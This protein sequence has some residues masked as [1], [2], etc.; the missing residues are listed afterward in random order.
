M[1]GQFADAANIGVLVLN[2]HSNTRTIPETQ[3][4]ARDAENAI[5]GGTRVVGAYDF[6]EVAVP[7]E[8]FQANRNYEFA[9]EDLAEKDMLSE[10]PMGLL[11]KEDLSPKDDNQ[12][13]KL[14]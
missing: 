4:T 7:R 10:P 8:G 14:I 6:M 3:Q 1:A 2:H 13:K 11:P 9:P 5:R 12:M